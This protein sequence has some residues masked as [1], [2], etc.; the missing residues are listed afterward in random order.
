MTY[1]TV[2]CTHILWMWNSS[3]NFTWLKPI[4]A[5]KLQITREDEPCRRSRCALHAVWDALVPERR[6]IHVLFDVSTE[7]DEQHARWAGNLDRYVVCGVHTPTNVFLE[8]TRATR[9]Q[10][11]W[12]AYEVGS[13]RR[14]RIRL[15]VELETVMYIGLRGWIRQRSV[16]SL[17]IDDGRTK[18]CLG[19]P[20][21][22][23]FR[24]VTTVA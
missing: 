12:H 16:S 10:S 17:C 24:I 9:R 11:E 6:G 23:E 22:A 5:R 20:T 1:I 15:A 19:E 2:R 4:A 14:I 21:S 7:A 3:V 13:R 8:A 18:N